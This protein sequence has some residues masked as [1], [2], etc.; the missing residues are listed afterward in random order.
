MLEAVQV[1]TTTGQRA[2]A[3]AIAAALVERRLAACVQ[4]SGPV[5]SCYRWQDK[6]QQ[7]EEWVCTIKTTTQAYE[8]VEQAIRELHPYEEPEILAMPIVHG[9]PSYLRWLADQVDFAAS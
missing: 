6:V 5:S 1:V 9:S 3:E 4:V 2:D 7:A 8:Y